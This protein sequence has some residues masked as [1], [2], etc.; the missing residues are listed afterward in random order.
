[1]SVG[2]NL[3]MAVINELSQEQ[4]P[5]LFLKKSISKNFAKFTGKYLCRSF[6]FNKVIEK[7]TLTQAFSCEFCDI[8][9]NTFLQNTP[10]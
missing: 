10:G 8:F 9:R 7:E 6:Y 1:M 4:P 2:K 5:E 3:E